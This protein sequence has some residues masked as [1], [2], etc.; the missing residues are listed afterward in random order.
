MQALLSLGMFAFTLSTLAHDELQRR[1]SWRHASNPRIGAR[2]ALQFTGP[3]EDTVSISGTAVAEL[4][5]G[6]A[7]LDQLRAMA[8]TGNPWPLVDGLG[9]VFGQFVI[10][11]LDERQKHFMPDGTPRRIDFGLDLLCVD[12]P[13]D[14]T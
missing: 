13:A 7:S 14:R 9:T 11:A 4:Q 5:D 6:R 1:T 3:G 12:A 8:A 10:T 2:D